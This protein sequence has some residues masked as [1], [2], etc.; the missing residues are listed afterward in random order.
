M[1]GDFYTIINREDDS[2]KLVDHREAWNN[3]T[4]VL[5]SE[6]NAEEKRRTMSDFLQGIRSELNI[7]ISEPPESA[8]RA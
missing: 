8:M 7:L 3:V 1:A 2:Q 6:A 4:G 5:E